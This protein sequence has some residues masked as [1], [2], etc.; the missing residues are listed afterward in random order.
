MKSVSVQELGAEPFILG[1]R[2]MI[3]TRNGKPVGVLLSVTEDS[4][5]QTLATVRRARATEAVLNMQQHAVETGRD[6]MSDE[7]IEREIQ[8]ARSAR[9]HEGRR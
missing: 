3:V 4:L 6:Q 2:E 7:E 1:D 9:R 5:T 8:A